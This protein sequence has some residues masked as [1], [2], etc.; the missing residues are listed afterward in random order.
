MK[1]YFATTKGSLISMVIYRL[2]FFFMLLGNL[3]YMT[4]VYFLWKSIYRGAITIH[5]M[6][7]N[8][9]F[10]YL[11]LA[12]SIYSF[13]FSG[14]DWQISSKIIHGGISIDLLKPLD[15]QL[16]MLARTAGYSLFNFI[17][18]TIPSVGIIFCIFGAEMHLGIGWIFFPLGIVM[19]FLINFAIDFAVGL[20]A[21]Y[22]ESLWGI[23]ITKAVIISM[24]SGALIPLQFFPQAIQKILQFLPFQAIYNLPLLM[25]TTPNFEFA[26]YVQL[27]AIQGFW[28][29][30]LFTV[31]RLLYSRALN[32]LTISGG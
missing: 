9:A 24:L 32:I 2:N 25:A 13:L 27:L 12:G 20:S 15:F 19:A 11:A 8:Q 7:F 30:L 31:C 26:Y 3:L 18:V 4:I 5:G 10:I 14:A 23:S 29:V 21:F 16:L 17:V 6:T 1:S 22:T 28:V